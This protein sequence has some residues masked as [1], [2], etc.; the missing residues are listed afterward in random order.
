MNIVRNMTENPNNASPFI[1]ELRKTI[2][3]FSEISPHVY[4]VLLFVYHS[5][6]QLPLTSDLSSTLPNLFPS[7]QMQFSKIDLPITASG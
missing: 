2:Q 1:G 6:Q 7:P 3:G 5:G 4:S